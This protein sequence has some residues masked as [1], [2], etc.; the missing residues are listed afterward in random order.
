MP[1]MAVPIAAAK[2][3]AWKRWAAELTGPRKAEF[4]DMNKRFG[5]TEHRAYLQPTPDGSFLAVVYTDGPG[6]DAFTP[7]IVK[8]DHPF[9]R[10]FVQSVADIHGIDPSG[11]LPPTPVRFL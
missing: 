7:S 1:A 10:W 5:I 11:Q 8:S 3:D 6:S 9:D 4:A 2:L